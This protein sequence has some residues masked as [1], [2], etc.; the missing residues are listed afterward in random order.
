[1]CVSGEKREFLYSV[2]VGAFA[3]SNVR[4]W[5]Q[6]ESFMLSF[7]ELLLSTNCVLGIAVVVVTYAISLKI[8]WL[9]TNNQRRSH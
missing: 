9:E 1:M 7:K 5:N 8:V 3:S 4:Y 6:V 2:K